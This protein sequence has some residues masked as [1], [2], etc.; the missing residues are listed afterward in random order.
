MK[1]GID[2]T[3]GP[4]LKQFI[5]IAVP[6]M[7]TSFIG[8]FYNIADTAVVGKFA[9]EDAMQAVAAVGTSGVLV[10]LLVNFFMGLAVGSNVVCANYYGARNYDGFSR[11]LHTSVMLGIVLG[12]PL[13]VF[14]WVASEPLLRMMGTPDDVIDKAALYMK[15]Y[16]SGTPVSMLNWYATSILRAMGDT[17][18][19]LYILIASGLL[20]IVLNIVCVVGLGMDVAGVAIGTVASQL[21]STVSI[22]RYMT[23]I[24]SEIRLSVKKLRLHKNEVKQIVKIGIPAGLDSIMFSLSNAVIQSAVNSFGSTV[25]AANSAAFKY[26]QLSNTLVAAGQNACVSFVGQNMGAKKYGRIKK[27]IKTSLIATSVVTITFDGVVALGGRFF[28][29]FFTNEAEVVNIGLK[30][31]Y[32]IVAPFFILGIS[33]ILGGSLRGMGYNNAP[34]IINLL[35][36]CLFRVVWVLFILPLHNTYE[37]LLLSYPVSWII[38]LTATLI[39][40]GHAKRKILK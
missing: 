17:K 24:E 27:V 38:T 26:N 39:V 22:L 12:V 15:I 32:I 33:G 19:P 8:M 20:N 30:Y 2:L 6:I 36:V 4:I 3:E 40:Y 5:K 35:G 28:M 25:L 14:G 34:M 13:A 29:S 9:G 31:L 21:Y 7:L 11:T 37:M 16:F 23:K 1:K 10:A 18:K